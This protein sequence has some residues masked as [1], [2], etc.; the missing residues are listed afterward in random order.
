VAGKLIFSV[1][2][3]E[4][5]DAYM[6][7]P[8]HF[9]E[10][11]LQEEGRKRS[12]FY[13]KHED[14]ASLARK[15]SRQ[16]YGS[17]ELQPIEEYFSQ[18]GRADKTSAI[19]IDAALNQA[20]LKS[21]AEEVASGAEASEEFTSYLDGDDLVVNAIYTQTDFSRNRFRQRQ[22]KE[23]KV[24]FEIGPESTTVTMPATAKGRE[25]VATLRNKIE[26][27]RKAVLEI[28]EVDLSGIPDPTLRTLFFTK[29]ASEFPNSTLND[30][31][32]VKLQGSNSSSTSETEEENGDDN[33]IDLDAEMTKKEEAVAGVLRGAALSGQDLF[34]TS[35][36]QDLRQRGFYITSI[37]WRSRLQEVGNPIVEFN[38]EFEDVETCTSFR[39]SANTWKVRRSTGEYNESFGSIPPPKRA[40]LLRRLQ[41]FAML[42]VQSIAAQTASAG[43]SVDKSG[44]DSEPS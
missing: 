42:T 13:S 5:F 43:S 18:I 6:S 9:T 32:R 20:E 33:E 2:D 16:V 36:F 12:I 40:E 17:R 31:L 10:K 27:K 44:G 8:S 19:R 26:E 39:Y 38:A 21:I 1:S 11:V 3:S 7:A 14:S 28:Q 25:I 34:G 23:A 22:Q 15:L 41:Q 24:R 4:I 29:L 35:V 30:V 37:T